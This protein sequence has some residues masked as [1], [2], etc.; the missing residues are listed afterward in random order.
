MIIRIL[1]EGQFELDAEKLADF[2]ELDEAVEHA[3]NVG[4]AEE[5]RGA[6]TRLLTEVHEMG[7]PVADDVITE[8]DLV[9]PAADSTL[10]EVKEMLS[11]E[12]LLPG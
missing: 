5:F 11:E 3:I 4:D 6:L 1:G 8:S 9:L 12:G 10:E 7:T 2:N